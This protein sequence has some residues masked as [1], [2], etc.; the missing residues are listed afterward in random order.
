MIIFI[1]QGTLEKSGKKS[2]SLRGREASVEVGGVGKEELER[3]DWKGWID[4]GR[5]G[6]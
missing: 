5:I 3:M 2:K 1:Q 6:K 4:S